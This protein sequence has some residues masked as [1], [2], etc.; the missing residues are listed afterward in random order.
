MREDSKSPPSSRF[1]NACPAGLF[2]LCNILQLQSLKGGTMMPRRIITI[3]P[4]LSNPLHQRQAQT[5]SIV[6]FQAS[7]SWL[8]TPVAFSVSGFTLNNQRF[9]QPSERSTCSSQSSSMPRAVSA[10]CGGG[11][12]QHSATVIRGQRVP[13]YYHALRTN[14]N[15]DAKV[16]SRLIGRQTIP[17]QRRG[18]SVEQVQTSRP[19]FIYLFLFSC[20]CAAVLTTRRRV[21]RQQEVACW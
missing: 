9:D 11:F 19:S 8:P 14:V 15:A 2:R 17:P 3:R 4:P 6:L 13:G 20:A 12:T 1:S 10:H 5:S 18:Q 21:G 7:S 16:N